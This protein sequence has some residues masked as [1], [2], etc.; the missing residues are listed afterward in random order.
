MLLHETDDARHVEG[1]RLSA[2]LASVREGDD[3]RYAAYAVAGGYIRR[4]LGV[5]LGEPNAGL[6]TRSRLFVCGRH[7]PARTAPR[8]PEIHD[9]RHGVSGNVALEVGRRQLGRM[10]VEQWAL[11]SAAFGSPRSLAQH[12]IGRIALRA[13]DVQRG[14]HRLDLQAYALPRPRRRSYLMFGIVSEI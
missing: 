5:E 14:A 11:A 4:V 1:S 13:D 3:R 6:E 9:E 8:R 7:H 2:H 12:A 10:T